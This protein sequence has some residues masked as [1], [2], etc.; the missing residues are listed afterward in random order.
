MEPKAS[1]LPLLQAWFQAF[2][3]WGQVLPVF[4]NL[5][6]GRLAV[7]GRKPELQVW[8]APAA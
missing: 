2:G 8:D 7:L 3:D 5:R 4:S 6:A 1:V